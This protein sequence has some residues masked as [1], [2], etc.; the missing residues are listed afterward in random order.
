MCHKKY[1]EMRL[2]KSGPYDAFFNNGQS[3]KKSL[4]V[5]AANK[6]SRLTVNVFSHLLITTSQGLLNL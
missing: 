4:M 2:T 3:S 5:F 1:K 6:S